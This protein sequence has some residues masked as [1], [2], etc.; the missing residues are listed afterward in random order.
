MPWEY[1]GKAMANLT[2]RYFFFATVLSGIL[3]SC[4]EPSTSAP[5]NLTG[6]DAHHAFEE[7]SAGLT[8]DLLY[9][10]QLHVDYDVDMNMEM[11]GIEEPMV[12]NM[13]MS[14]DFLCDS[15]QEL[16]SW[17]SLG[18]DIDLEGEQ[19]VFALDLQC[20]NNTDGL[21]LLLDDH[22]FFLEEAGMEM[23]QAVQLSQDRVTILVNMYAEVL[24]EAMALYGPDFVAMWSNVAGPGELFHPANMIRFVA[25]TDSFSVFAWHAEKGKITIGARLNPELLQ[26]ALKS[27]MQGAEMP[28]DPAIFNDMIFEMVVEEATGSMLD[29]SFAM[30]LPMEVPVPNMPDG[31]LAMNMGLK[32]RLAALPV[33]P[34][35]PSVT[36]PADVL[37]LDSLFD[38]FLPMIQAALEMQRQ[39]MRQTTGE[40]DSEDDF[41]F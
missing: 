33:S 35:A 10:V 17:G 19:R 11:Q 38:Q 21:R 30:E 1:Y 13:E 31:K 18:F 24:G 23:P 3:V 22:G 15:A 5:V 32:M 29:Y 4:Q 12:M 36:L 37:V 14:M 25:S 6:E 41:S 40:Q 20:A 27:T 2:R 26:S 7:W 34:D 28:F 8:A 16:R 39:Q 9:P